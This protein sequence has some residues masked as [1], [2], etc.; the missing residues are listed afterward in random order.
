MSNKW[1]LIVINVLDFNRFYLQ[2]R[3]RIPL[4]F[5][6]KLE[7]LQGFTVFRNR[8]A[9][10]TQIEQ[11]GTNRIASIGAALSL[12]SDLDCSDWEFLWFLLI[13]LAK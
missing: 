12:G 7:L 3:Q 1:K 13:P 10:R 11:A 2:I 4:E 9:Q 8:E 6:L 5:G